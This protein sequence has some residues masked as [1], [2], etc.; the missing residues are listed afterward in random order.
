MGS[1][2]AA[3]TRRSLV[4][5]LKAFAGTGASGLLP[6]SAS[7]AKAGTCV[8]TGPGLRRGSGGTLVQTS[9]INLDDQFHV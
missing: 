7:P 5:H 2:D 9:R 6:R 8:V 4:P 3:S 1:A